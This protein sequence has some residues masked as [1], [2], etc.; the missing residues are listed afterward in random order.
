MT[1]LT[2]AQPT[3]LADQASV[4]ER[5]KAL[6]LRAAQDKRVIRELLST[7]HGR[8]WMWHVLE[9]CH[10]LSTSFAEEP[11]VMAFREGERN[12]GLRLWGQIQTDAPDLLLTMLAEKG[13]ANG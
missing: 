2:R 3:N 8:S 13:V 11:T 7:G 9:Q 5:Q 12:I 1:D 6:I 10:M 4:D